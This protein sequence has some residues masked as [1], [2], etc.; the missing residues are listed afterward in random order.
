[1]MRESV[2]GPLE[3]WDDVTHEWRAATPEEAAYAQNIEY[4]IGRQYG[5]LQKQAFAEV[6]SAL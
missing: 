3:V 4:A 1:M 6:R 5:E 2:N